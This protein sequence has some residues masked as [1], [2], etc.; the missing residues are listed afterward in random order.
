[1]LTKSSRRYQITFIVFIA[2][3]TQRFC[4]AEVFTAMSDME[5]LL[6]TEAVLINNLEAY[7]AAHETKL[8]YLKRWVP[9]L[10]NGHELWFMVFRMR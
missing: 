7:V 8:N 9:L 6:E 4:T 2:I 3:A 10:F 5:E 1:M